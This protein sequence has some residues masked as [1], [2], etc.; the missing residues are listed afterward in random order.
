M[1]TQFFTRMA[2]TCTAMTPKTHWQT[3]KKLH[4]DAAKS[5]RIITQKI[6]VFFYFNFVYLAC[7]ILSHA[8]SST[9]WAFLGVLVALQVMFVVSLWHRCIWCHLFQ[10]PK[11]TIEMLPRCLLAFSVENIKGMYR[12]SALSIL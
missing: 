3:L 1:S 6:K 7:P 5:T 11:R 4:Y 12:E 2:A 8:L 9:V 10:S